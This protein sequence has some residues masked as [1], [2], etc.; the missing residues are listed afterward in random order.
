MTVYYELPKTEKKA[1]L[2]TGSVTAA[3]PVSAEKKKHNKRERVLQS[4]VN[5]S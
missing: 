3:G 5:R 4:F 1:Q 2:D